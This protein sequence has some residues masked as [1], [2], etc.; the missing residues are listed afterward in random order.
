MPKVTKK[1]AA[2]P[3]QE[4]RP[5][6]MEADGQDEASVR[7]QFPPLSV[8][9]QSGSRLEFRRVPVPSHRMT[10]LKNNWLALYKPITETLKLD[11]RM[12]L[13]SRKVTGRSYPCERE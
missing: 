13:K 2:L 10:P 6:A 1:D 4:A 7:P 11:V 9:E 3:L 12:N 5:V 8:S